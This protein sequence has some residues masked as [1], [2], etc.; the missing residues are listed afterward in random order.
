MLTKSEQTTTYASAVRELMVAIEFMRSTCEHTE[1][2]DDINDQML[3]RAM[4]VGIRMNA[5]Y[6]HLLEDYHKDSFW[7][8]V[9]GVARVLDIPDC[10]E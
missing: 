9:S 5:R 6:S 1:G 10:D 2:R 8:D 3:S 4:S 7:A